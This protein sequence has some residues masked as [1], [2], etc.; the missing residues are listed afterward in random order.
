VGK[1]LGMMPLPDRTGDRAAALGRPG[2]DPAPGRASLA[3]VDDSLPGDVAAGDAAKGTRAGGEESDEVLP[4]ALLAAVEVS[5]AVGRPVR[6]TAPMSLAAG[7][8]YRGEG[9]TVT[10]TVAD[11]FLGSL[12]SLARRRGQPL[13]RVGEE[14]W[15]LNGG[16][17]AVLRASGLTVKVTISGS[18]ARSLPPD[19]LPRLAAAVAGRLAQR[20]A[21][22][23]QPSFPGFGNHKPGQNDGDLDENSSTSCWPP[24]GLCASWGGVPAGPVC[25]PEEPA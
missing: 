17:T 25:Q 7:A 19:A 12:T 20:A 3:A 16:R 6:A 8:L 9:V 21:P 24:P 11:G 10:V 13:P 23:G 22:C 4:G 15:L 1:L 2:A 18:A 5:A 14:A